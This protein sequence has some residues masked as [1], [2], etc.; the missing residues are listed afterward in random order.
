MF[1]CVSLEI[2][3][4]LR[5]LSCAQSLRGRL[6]G[7]GVDR[8]GPL[9]LGLPQGSQGDI[10]LGDE[11]VQRTSLREPLMKAPEQKTWVPPLS[12]QWAADPTPFPRARSLRRLRIES[13][14]F[15]RSARP[16]GQLHKRTGI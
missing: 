11:G 2:V 13:W 12:E 5:G 10:Y 8:R 14:F 7:W 3:M 16:C 4:F 15:L 1:M 9:V 6:P